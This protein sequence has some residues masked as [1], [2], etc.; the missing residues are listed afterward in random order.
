MLPVVV[1][2]FCSCMCQRAAASWWFV[3]VFDLQ[4]SSPWDL[5]LLCESLLNRLTWK[6]LWTLSEVELW[7]F[8]PAE[9]H[10]KHHS[11]APQMQLKC[12]SKQFY[13][14]PT[15]IRPFIIHSVAGPS[16]NHSAGFSLLS[17]RVKRNFLRVAWKWNGVAKPKPSFKNPT[18]CYMWLK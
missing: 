14:A 17:G 2:V 5:Q 3:P 7:H 18:W 6:R 12:P 13:F 11:S 16:F 1:S 4:D 9:H 15:H 8:C 10:M